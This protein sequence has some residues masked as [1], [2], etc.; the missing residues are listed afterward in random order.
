MSGE[1]FSTLLSPWGR[2]SF[3]LQKERAR[4]VRIIIRWYNYSYETQRSITVY[5]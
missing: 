2:M 5:R 4:M 1:A 3:T